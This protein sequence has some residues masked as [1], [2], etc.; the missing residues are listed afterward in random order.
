MMF[1]FIPM[2]Y[3]KKA[4]EIK[5]K[6]KWGVEENEKIKNKERKEKKRREGVIEGIREAI[7]Y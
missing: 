4:T 3:R 7:K 5:E 6:K 1:L 2:K